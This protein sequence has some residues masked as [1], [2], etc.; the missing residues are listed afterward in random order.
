MYNSFIER[1]LLN[2]VQAVLNTSSNT[3]IVLASD[4]GD[5]ETDTSTGR[6]TFTRLSKPSIYDVRAG[7]FYSPSKIRLPQPFEKGALIHAFSGYR[8]ED[9]TRSGV[10]GGKSLRNASGN[11]SGNACGNGSVSARVVCGRSTSIGAGD[12]EAGDDAIGADWSW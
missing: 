2:M 10:L 8:G 3:T 4:H 12:D 7:R 11:A 5:G 6:H 1:N 9:G